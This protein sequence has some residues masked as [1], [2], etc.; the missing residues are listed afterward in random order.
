MLGGCF[1]AITNGFNVHYRIGAA[2]IRHII[3][4]N[5]S[6]IVKRNETYKWLYNYISTY[7]N[8]K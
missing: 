2:N 7:V 5:Q 1:S 6:V 3:T 8:F 4:V